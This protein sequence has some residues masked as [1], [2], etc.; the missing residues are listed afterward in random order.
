VGLLQRLYIGGD[1]MRPDRRQRQTA[2]FVEV[3]S[4]AGAMMAG[5]GSRLRLLAN[6]AQQP[7]KTLCRPLV[8]VGG[9]WPQRLTGGHPAGFDAI[10]QEIDRRP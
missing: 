4:A 5:A 9:V 3:A 7:F 8:Q 2:T 6:L 1:V 10:A